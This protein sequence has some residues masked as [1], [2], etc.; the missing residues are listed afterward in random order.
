MAGTLARSNHAVY[1]GKPRH[2]EEDARKS[3]LSKMEALRAEGSNLSGIP[4]EIIAN[5]D[6]CIEMLKHAINIPLR[7]MEDDEK[8]RKTGTA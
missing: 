3:F 4:S 2:T 1:R 5:L 6:E 8:G 7:V